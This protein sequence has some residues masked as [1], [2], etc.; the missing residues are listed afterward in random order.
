M[1]KKKSKAI[2]A[3]ELGGWDRKSVSCLNV[4]CQKNKLPNPDWHVKIVQGNG[5][6]MITAKLVMPDGSAVGQGPNQ[7]E[8]KKKAV[9][10]YARDVLKVDYLQPGKFEAKKAYEKEVEEQM[11][12]IQ[13]LR[14]EEA[15]LEYL[16]RIK[17]QEEKQREEQKQQAE[18]N[19]VRKKVNE[20]KRN[21]LV[22]HLENAQVDK[23]ST[24]N[25]RGY[26]IT[27]VDGTQYTLDISY[28]DETHE[29][30]YW[31]YPDERYEYYHY[32]HP[33]PEG[34][35]KSEVKTMSIKCDKVAQG[36]SSSF[37][38]SISVPLD[39]YPG[40]RSLDANFSKNLKI[41]ASKSKDPEKASNALLVRKLLE[42]SGDEIYKPK[43]KSKQNSLVQKSG[44]K[45]M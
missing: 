10:N 8:A 42:V 7:A 13:R 2:S 22:S 34:Y 21:N 19:R 1:A 25:G 44:N 5:N 3:N 36:Q 33:E 27:T 16:E 39:S 30:P 31:R 14:F 35:K 43:E 37:T 24:E 38:I 28:K 9:F 26:R 17:Q 6:T 12:E 32:G 40:Q 11:A 18:L 20:R 45:E 4:Y 29:K 15:H 23:L 41:M